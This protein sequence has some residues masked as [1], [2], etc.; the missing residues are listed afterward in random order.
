MQIPDEDGYY[1]KQYYTWG[2][3]IKSIC[4]GVKP[5]GDIWVGILMLDDDICLG[6]FLDEDKE[7]LLMKVGNLKQCN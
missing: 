7:K 6:T 3:G 5:K 1:E 4:I 2:K